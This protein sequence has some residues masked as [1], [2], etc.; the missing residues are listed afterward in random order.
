[1]AFETRSSAERRH[2]PAASPTRPPAGVL[3]RLAFRALVGLWH[4]EQRARTTLRPLQHRSLLLLTLLPS[5][6]FVVALWLYCGL[7]Y[8][9]HPDSLPS[10]IMF[11]DLLVPIGTALT[12]VSAI[13]FSLSLFLQQSVSDL[14]SPQYFSANSYGRLQK[15]A[16]TLVV[17]IV[18]GQL[19]YG[20]YLRALGDAPVPHLFFGLLSTFFG[21]ALV[22][23]LLLWQYLYVARKTTPAEAIRFLHADATRRFRALHRQVLRTT[24]LMRFQNGS[25]RPETLALV[26]SEVLPSWIERLLRPIHALSEITV[27]LSSRGN[28][29]AARHGLAAL[30]DALREYLAYRRT[31]SLA[32]SSPTHFLAVESDSQSLLTA[33]FEKLHELGEGFLRSGQVESARSV[34]DSYHALAT[35]ANQM[36]FI[37]RSQEN[38][39][40]YQIAYYL[41]NYVD[42]AIQLNDDEVPFRA[43]ETFVQI[44]E[45]AAL[46]SDT[47]IVD[48]VAKNLATITV[49]GAVSQ[50]WFISERCYLGQHRL[51]RALFQWQ[52]NARI[53]FDEVLK[54]FFT[55][56]RAPLSQALT[57]NS[58]HASAIALRQPF[59]ELQQLLAWVAAEHRQRDAS[60]R[61]DLSSAFVSFA[62]P[63]YS[64]L[65]SIG[66]AINL[67]SGYTDVISELIV[68]VV[69]TLTTLERGE[70]GD[71]IAKHVDWFICLPSWIGNRRQVMNAPRGLE[72]VIDGACKIA[73][74]LIARDGPSDRVLT[75]MD[76]QFGIVKRALEHNTGGS[77]YYE[78][79][80]M[81][82]LCY[83]GALAAKYRRRDGVEKARDLIATFDALHQPKP[84][85]T[86]AVPSLLTEFLRW[87]DD[88]EEHRRPSILDTASEI[89]ANEVGVRDVDAFLAD[90]WGYEIAGDRWTGYD[91]QRL[92]TRRDVLGR[93]IAIL[94]RRIDV[95]T[96][97]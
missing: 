57:A 90:A 35:E 87:R 17:T 38:P 76:T 16:F 28:H 83:C 5:L 69:R 52:G 96:D 82:R 84:T 61:G 75:A 49:R 67:T 91:L 34:V 70:P 1:M 53:C 73:L 3:R 45:R 7:L 23:S 39:I 59:V 94:R 63:L 42:K 65:R 80:L 24:W 10:A 50:S 41:K 46:R 78:P 72:N 62:D 48:T 4:I 85:R 12:G 20:F 60:R 47:I 64:H 2:D 92:G 6:G 31:S 11:G 54:Q 26:Y 71:R 44:G 18:L 29:V 27:R 13:A 95:E 37:G 81:L 8:S 30:T 68:A 56:H 58:S 21:T 25:D 88:V 40:A 32:S 79:R 51:L 43:I 14:Y 86:N 15:F 22:F 33:A 77:G 74:F 93:L 9:L 89:V 19:S 36:E 55:L 97:A 66:E